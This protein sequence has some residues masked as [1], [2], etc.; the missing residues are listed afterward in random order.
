VTDEGPEQVG[1]VGEEAAKLFAAIAGAARGQGGPYAG[2]AAGAASGMAAAASEAAR[3][4]SEHL[5]TESPE[6]TWCPVCRVVHAVR[7][8]SPEVRHH[9]AVAASAL[10]QAAAGWLATDV[11][12]DERSRTGPVQTIDLDEEPGEEGRGDG[13]SGDA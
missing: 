9:L 11:P 7:Q 13:S 8:S 12:A 10:A 2:A 4:V 3:E 1:S 5:A 6:C